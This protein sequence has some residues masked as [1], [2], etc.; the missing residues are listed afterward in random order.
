VIDPEIKTLT[1]A[2]GRKIAVKALSVVDQAQIMRTAGPAQA[3][4]QPYVM[5]IECLY[6]VQSI[7]GNATMRPVNERQ[8][9]AALEKLGDDGMARVMEYRYA[10]M[11]AVQE[12]A[13]RAA[14]GDEEAAER[15][16]PL[17]RPASSPNSDH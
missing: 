6:M 3:L 17:Q 9:D 12:A 15:R 1:D 5:M 13:E 8:V 16:D 11:L 2:T 14:R 7:D 4:N 10:E